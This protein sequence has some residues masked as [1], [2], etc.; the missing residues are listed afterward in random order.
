VSS[1]LRRRFL[2]DAGVCYLNHGAFGAAPIRASSRSSTAPTRPGQVP[3]DLR[4]LGVD[5]YTGNAHKW[6]VAP[7]GAGFSTCVPS[8]TT[9]WARTSSCGA[10][11][12]GF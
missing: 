3:V 10:S 4:G 1:E 8:I 7:K 11:A 2:V 9:G 5:I 12:T 6:L